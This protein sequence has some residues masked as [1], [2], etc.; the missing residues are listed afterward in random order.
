VT[1]E[2]GAVGGYCFYMDGNLQNADITAL[3]LTTVDKNGTSG[4]AP[5]TLSSSGF[6]NNSTSGTWTLPVTAWA[7]DFN[8]YLAF[9]FGNG[10]GSP[11]SFVVELADGATGGAWNFLAIDPDKT[12]GLS[13]YY[14]LSGPGGVVPPDQIPEPAS[15]ALIGLGLLAAAA[16]RRRRKD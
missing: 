3:G 5:G 7:G 15:A 10:G 9:H 13:N 4:S 16:V 6:V 2:N 11:D 1:V 8:L 12:N 14:L